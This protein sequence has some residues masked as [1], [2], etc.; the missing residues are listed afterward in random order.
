V[1]S[2]F[3][4]DKAQQNNLLTIGANASLDD[5]GLHTF[6]VDLF[7]VLIDDGAKV[8]AKEVSAFVAW[9]VKPDTEGKLGQ[10]IDPGIAQE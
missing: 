10:S 7:H 5:T 2:I 4:T 9:V 6:L 8:L 1:G 3:L